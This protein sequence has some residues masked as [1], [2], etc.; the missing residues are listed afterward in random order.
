[1]GPVADVAAGFRLVRPRGTGWSRCKGPMREAK[2][3]NREP[4]SGSD[5]E[6]TSQPSGSCPTEARKLN[7]RG[8]RQCFDIASHRH[9]AGFREV[10]QEAC[11]AKSIGTKRRNPQRSGDLASLLRPGD[12]AQ[13]GRGE[14]H[15]LPTQSQLDPAD[16]RY[17]NP[18]WPAQTKRLLPASSSSD[19]S[20]NRYSGSTS[21]LIRS[22]TTS[23]NPCSFSRCLSSSRELNGSKSEGTWKR[24][25][26]L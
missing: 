2:E 15:F 11:E 10:M 22:I 24:S 26:C 9:L 5:R 1:M 6:G 3:E 7:A 16:P 17:A 25:I 23:T 19:S 20:P 8:T 14:G 4:D 12:G 18:R 21:S 13:S